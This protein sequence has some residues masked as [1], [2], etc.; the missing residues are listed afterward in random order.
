[1]TWFTDAYNYHQGSILH[2]AYELINL[3]LMKILS[4]V[5]IILMVQSAHNFAHVTT[6]EL[7]WHVQNCDLIRSSFF[8]QEQHES[9]QDLA[10][11]FINL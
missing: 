2:K 4:D 9:L 5:I 1:M 7:S 11:V 6:A 3:N 10:N 8:K